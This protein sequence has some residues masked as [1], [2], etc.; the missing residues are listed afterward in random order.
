[1]SLARMLGWML[2]QAAVQKLSGVASGVVLARLLGPE[3]LGIVA[4][5]VNLANAA[6]GMLRGG[7]DM[8]LHATLAG[9][10]DSPERKSSLVR[11][12]LV[13]LAGGSLVGA[14]GLC[15]FPVESAR[16]FM[17]SDALAGWVAFS[18]GMVVLLAGTH[19]AAAVLAGEML[20]QAYSRAMIA[21]SLG[22]AIALSLGALTFGVQGV[23]WATLATQ[24]VQ[25]GQLAASIPRPA[26]RE[27]AR[28]GMTDARAGVQLL[29]LGLPFA[30]TLLASTPVDLY[31]QALLV[32]T[33][34][35]EAVGLLRV[36]T[37][38][39]SLIAFVPATVAPVLVSRL[40]QSRD[41]APGAEGDAFRSTLSLNVRVVGVFAAVIGGVIA[42]LAFPLVRVLY[43]D[44]FD[45]AV[46]VTQVGCLYVATNC[47][48]QSVQVAL[49][50]DKR[51]DLLFML[52]LLQSSTAL[53]VGQVLVPTHGA[54]GFI[55][56]QL[57]GSCL[58]CLSAIGLAVFRWSLDWRVRFGAFALWALLT[59]AGACLAWSQ[60]RV[61]ANGCLLAL[62]LVALL[63]GYLAMSPAER[64]RIRGLFAGLVRA[65]LRE[66]QGLNRD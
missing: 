19:F 13:L 21:N 17:G 46:R 60:S 47:L 29:A 61:W 35:V 31:L 44:A 26:V 14:L 9:A 64:A 34:G 5:V 57:V 8:S 43:G 56:A 3:G 15:V 23:L 12:G 18:A 45:S 25:V 30:G 24:A 36:Q 37:A 20:F 33:S 42:A 59:S 6:S 41:A 62:A 63:V 11:A 38:I 53:I 27:I 4:A 65:D 10:S 48:L 39:A 16:H 40:A 2:S 66:G 58:S 7:V 1:M 22:S 54:S 32:R 51:S 28:F 50:A 52:A 55:F 49:M